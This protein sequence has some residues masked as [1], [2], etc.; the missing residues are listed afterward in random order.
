MASLLN[1]VPSAIKDRFSSKKHSDKKSDNELDGSDNV[2]ND[3][4]ENKETPSRI[5]S[6]VE[7][8]AEIQVR[9]IARYVDMVKSKHEGDSPAQVQE[10]VNK[11]FRRLAT[12][13][14]VGAGASAAVPGVGT[15]ASLGV[16]TG[17]AFLFL[18]LTTWYTLSSAYL[19]GIDI[20]RHKDRTALVLLAI[21]G[22][23]ANEAIATV[24][25][26]GSVFR[27]RSLSQ[28]AVGQVNNQLASMALKRIRK[29]AATSMVA[30]AL[31]LGIGALMGGTLNRKIASKAIEHVSATLGEPPLVWPD[32]T[33]ALERGDAGTSDAATALDNA[34]EKMAQSGDD[35]SNDKSSSD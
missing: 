3:N 16:S 24:L 28:P 13:T 25:G 9:P 34:W 1:V 8:A 21:N 4:L 27:L 30:K 32:T 33:R 6:A 18:E 2:E 35:K 31:P 5:L 10:V 19:R 23:S 14:G 11:H 22:S 20:S 26:S 7:R 29:R 15:L 12:T 17:D